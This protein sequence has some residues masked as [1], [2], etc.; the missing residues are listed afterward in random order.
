MSKIIF[1]AIG[2]FKDLCCSY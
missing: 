1:I 2:N